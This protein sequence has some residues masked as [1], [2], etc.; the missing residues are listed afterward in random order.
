MPLKLGQSFS[1]VKPRLDAGQLA[2]L[3]SIL[4]ANPKMARYLNEYGMESAATSPFPIAVIPPENYLQL[5]RKYEE[6]SGEEGNLAG[7]LH[8]IQRDQPEAREMD[9]WSEDTTPDFLK[10]YLKHNKRAPSSDIYYHKG[11]G[12]PRGYDLHPDVSM[13]GSADDWTVDT[14]GLP[15]LKWTPRGEHGISITDHEGRGRNAFAAH[16]HFSLPIQM[17]ERSAVLPDDPYFPTYNISDTLKRMGRGSPELND[18]AQ[19]ALHEFNEPVSLNDDP[20]DFDKALGF[21]KGT[22]YAIPEDYIRSGVNRTGEKGGRPQGVPWKFPVFAE[23]G[24][25]NND[26]TG[27]L[28]KISYGL[29]GAANLPMG[30]PFIGGMLPRVAEGLASEYYG[31]NQH[32]DVNLGGYTKDAPLRDRFRPNVA[33]EPLGLPGMFG[34]KPSEEALHDSSRTDTAVRDAFGLGDETGFMDSAAYLGGKSLAVPILSA[35]RGLQTISGPLLER[36]P[37][38]LRYP[39]RAAEMVTD[40]FNPLSGRVRDTPAAGA[41]GATL[42]SG[43][44]EGMKMAADPLDEF[45]MEINDTFGS[46]DA[47]L[48]ALQNGDERAQ[49]FAHRYARL[50]KVEQN[51]KDYAEYLYDAH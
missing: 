17:M 6:G 31:V 21:L 24:S 26:D 27:L 34:H 3:S 18:Q 15:V 47:F 22:R 32:G 10:G 14:G 50:K 25:V 30:M 12:L 20:M 7:L 39:L 23:G 29:Q 13:H 38:L 40:L 35:G 49:D 48:Q 11:V 9:L 37:S 46:P 41:F 16:E 42:Q 51:K 4:D 45:E 36:A 44:D 8:R 43:I 28:R 33:I 5:A 19:R 2:R 1:R